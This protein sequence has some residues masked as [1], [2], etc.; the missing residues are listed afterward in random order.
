MEHRINI[1]ISVKRIKIFLALFAILVIAVILIEVFIVH[2]NQDSRT[3]GF[4][5]IPTHEPYQMGDGS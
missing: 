5:P 3:K 2:D 1:A 4:P